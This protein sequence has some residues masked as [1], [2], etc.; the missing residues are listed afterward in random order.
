M[1]KYL[2][3][4]HMFGHTNDI[5]VVYVQNLYILCINIIF[6]YVYKVLEVF[7]MGLKRLELCRKRGKLI[8]VKLLKNV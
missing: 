7:T 1:A 5:Q 8:G 4:K 2:D 3:S 6:V